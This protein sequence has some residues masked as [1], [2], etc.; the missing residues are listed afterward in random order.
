MPEPL[1]LKEVHIRRVSSLS[2]ANTQALNDPIRIAILEILSHKQMSA[3]EITKM[4]ANL[5][6]N[7]AITTVRHHLDTLKKSGLI[8]TAKIVEVRGTVIKY[9]GPTMRIFDY[10]L[11]TDF[12]NNH[13]K[14]VDEITLKINKI[15]KAILEDKKLASIF[16]NKTQCKLC[17]NNHFKEYVA[18]EIINA[19]IAKAMK[20]NDFVEMISWEKKEPHKSLKT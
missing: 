6:H 20:E 8:E 1:F 18:L 7:K 13:T 10:E 11:P 17:K 5:G 2:Y 16:D 14:L 12:E 9:Y 4:L 19:A 3:E 15:L